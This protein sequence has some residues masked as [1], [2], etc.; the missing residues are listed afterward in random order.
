MDF[1]YKPESTYEIKNDFFGHGVTVSGLLTGK[2][3]INQL[4]GKELG[5]RLFMTKNA[6][7]SG[8]DLFLCG[9]TVNELENALGVKA[10]F[11]PDD[12]YE[13]IGMLTQ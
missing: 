11:C 5:E 1:Y 2:D 13:F 12:G 9:N 4:S 8:E 7:K 3:I 6:L 10:E